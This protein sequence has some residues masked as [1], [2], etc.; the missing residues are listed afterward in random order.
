MKPLRRR[1]AVG[2][3]VM[4]SLILIAVFEMLERAVVKVLGL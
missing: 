1:T 3:G 4:L 2:I